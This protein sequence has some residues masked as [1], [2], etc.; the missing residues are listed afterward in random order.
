MK[1]IEAAFR[2][3]QAAKEIF[4][5][6]APTIV[7]EPKLRDDKLRNDELEKVWDDIQ[8]VVNGYPPTS[9]GRIFKI[10]F[11]K[12]PSDI[13]DKL[14]EAMFEGIVAEKPIKRDTKHIFYAGGNP[15]NAI[16]ASRY[17]GYGISESKRWAL[18]MQEK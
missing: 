18:W 6:L 13:R 9:D 12:E 10:V 2:R 11:G 3:L 4:E 1:I 5:E 14:F 15:L 7:S 8:A 17:L 16:T